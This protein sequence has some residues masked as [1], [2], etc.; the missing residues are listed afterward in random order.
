MAAAAVH[1]DSKEKESDVGT[2]G[3][4]SESVF[5][6]SIIIH[7]AWHRSSYFAYRVAGLQASK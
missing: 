7:P 5:C 2:F 1:A 6:C 4:S 3:T